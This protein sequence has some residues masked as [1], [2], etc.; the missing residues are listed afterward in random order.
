MSKVKDFLTSLINVI[1]SFS[2]VADVLAQL[3]ELS[4][5]GSVRSFFKSLGRALLLTCIAWIC[6][7][8]IPFIAYLWSEGNFLNTAV[9][10]FIG[11]VLFVIIK[12]CLNFIRL[13]RNQDVS[14]YYQAIKREKDS[15]DIAFSN[16]LEQKQKYLEGCQ[17][18]DETIVKSLLVCLKYL[19][20]S[21]EK[22]KDKGKVMRCGL[23][24]LDH[25]NEDRMKVMLIHAP[26]TRNPIGR[27]TFDKTNDKTNK[28]AIKKAIF[29]WNLWTK[30]GSDGISSE[31]FGLPHIRT[32]AYEYIGDTITYIKNTPEEDRIFDFIEDKQEKYLK[33]MI[34]NVIYYRTVEDKIIPLALLNFDCSI[35]NYISLNEYIQ[36]KQSHL[37]FYRLI[38]SILVI[39]GRETFGPES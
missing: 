9:A 12:T 33:M 13:Y 38:G 1:R 37:S 6:L 15:M 11:I 19:S 25:K 7:F 2:D 17:N 36:I 16:S 5:E 27:R 20:E 10:I 34:G 3:E 18:K 32:L 4:K 21:L 35:S 22:P 8:A 26:R 24:V 28:K 30:F 31:G 29:N 39:L 23:I 14:T